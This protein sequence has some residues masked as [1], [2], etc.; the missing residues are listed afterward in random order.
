MRACTDVQ[1]K[2]CTRK[3][4]AFRAIAR[5]YM[6]ANVEQLDTAVS[7]C[8]LA[9]HVGTKWMFA[10]NVCRLGHKCRG[11]KCC[12]Q[13]R[14]QAYKQACRASPLH[15]R[16]A[17]QKH[18]IVRAAGSTNRL[19]SVQPKKN[20]L[21]PQNGVS[22]LGKQLICLKST[23]AAARGTQQTKRGH[24]EASRPP[25]TTPALLTSRS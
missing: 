20:R 23:A 6:H 10:L 2:A 22:R 13:A 21:Y 19:A 11:S 4:R 7:A 8:W 25:P 12:K 5:T 24:H 1:L 3:Q 14:T 15:K 17:L 18:D 9:P 16:N